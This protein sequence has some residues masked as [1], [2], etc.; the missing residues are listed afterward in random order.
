MGRRVP[1]FWTNILM[2]TASN[3]SAPAARQWQQLAGLP[4]AQMLHEIAMGL[5]MC[6][7]SANELSKS[8]DSLGE[9]SERARAI[10][11]LHAEEEASKALMLLDLV[12]C[13]KNSQA[14]RSKLAKSIS[15]H[16]AR[17]I[18]VENCSW[19]PADFG[20][21][22]TIVD[23]ARKSAYRDGPN[24]DDYVYA[25]DLLTEREGLLYVDR[26]RIGDNYRWKSPTSVDD[27]RLQEDF[28]ALNVVRALA[29]VGCFRID[30]LKIIDR[31]W[32]KF[33]IDDSKRRFEDVAPLD[34]AVR[35]EFEKC[36]WL[37]QVPT[38]H[39]RSL[40]DWPM[41]LYHLD[42]NLDTP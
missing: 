14:E 31:V 7:D 1:I 27:L 41:P 36:G 38:E 3:N 20:E 17:L 18:Y 22:R 33:R 42:L 23:D 24:G 4:R 28:Y 6:L 10:L 30:G 15:S 9:G 34:R 2:S 8:A 5:R 13:P 40:L 12:R 11:R 32:S 29:A 21:L 37:A 19:K 16:L 26:E 39:V 35:N 25:N